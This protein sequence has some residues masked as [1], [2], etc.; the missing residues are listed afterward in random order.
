[1]SKLTKY[2]NNAKGI[3]AFLLGFS[4]PMVLYWFSLFFIYLV[5]YST[6][7]NPTYLILNGYIAMPTWIFLK[8]YK[9]KSFRGG[10]IFSFISTIIISA[11]LGSVYNIGGF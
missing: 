7:F 1:M 4:V 11:V 6:E 9:N 3:K 8:N 10:V 5:Q 2:M